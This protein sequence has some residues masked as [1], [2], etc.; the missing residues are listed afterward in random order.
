[1]NPRKGSNDKLQEVFDLL[2]FSADE[3]HA[4]ETFFN[5]EAGQEALDLI[6]FRDLSAAAPDGQ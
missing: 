4:A 6:A 2:V 1:M 5:K 3:R